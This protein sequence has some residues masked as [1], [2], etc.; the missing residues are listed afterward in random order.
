MKLSYYIMTLFFNIMPMNLS[1]EEE[2]GAQRVSDRLPGS[3]KPISYR[4]DI[5]LK[6]GVPDSEVEEEKSEFWGKV[7]I[8]AK[9]LENTREVVL[10]AEKL[11]IAS[12][13]VRNEQN[14]AISVSYEHK[15]PLLK[16]ET[17]ELKKDEEFSVEIEYSAK[18]SEG[19]SG[20]YK[21][22]DRTQGGTRYI[23]STQFEA[24]H[25]RTAFPCW[26]EPEYK[27]YFTISITAPKKFVVLSNSNEESVEAVEIA[28]ENREKLDS[29]V[30][31]KKVVF[32]PTLLMST[33][34]LAWVIGELESVDDGKIRVFS[35]KGS[36]EHGRYSLG[37]AKHCLEYFNEYFAVPYQMSK[38]DMVAIPDFSAG[39]M[40][41]WG[42][43]T[44]RS[45]SLHYIEGSTTEMQKMWIAETVCHELAH[46]WFG[47]LVTMKWW[48]DLWLNEGFATWAGT[49][50]TASIADKI[51]LKYDVW[52]SF[53]E[54]DITRGMNMDGKLSTHPINMPVSST[55]DISSIFDAISYSKGGSMIHMLANY[56]GYDR[57]KEGLRRYIK[58]HQYKNTVTSD[59]WNSVD[60]DGSKDVTESMKNWIDTAGMPVVHVSLRDGAV[61]LRQ[62]RYLPN[63]TSPETRSLWNVFLTKKQIKEKGAK[64]SSVMFKEERM[65]VPVSEM[66]FIL[67]ENAAGF[68]RVKYSKEVLEKYVKPLLL[69]EHLTS[70]DRYG[71]FRDMAKY[72][73][74][75]Y[76]DAGYL[77]EMLPYISKNEKCAVVSIFAEFLGTVK[78]LF[79]KNERI[80]SAAE[81]ALRNLLEPYEKNV[82]DYKRTSADVE[83]R[84]L[85]IL[86]VSALATIEGTRTQKHAMKIIAGEVMP[87]HINEEYRMRFYI[88]IAKFGDKSSGKDVKER[89]MGG[90]DFLYQIING[91][92]D[93]PE[94]LRATTAIAFSEERT[95]D[96]FR[97]FSEPSKVIRDQDKMR[98]VSGLASNRD[99]K[100]VLAMFFEKFGKIRKMFERTPDHV[101]TFVHG[102]LAP[103]HERDAIEMAG[104][105]FEDSANVE[106]AWKPS[107][108]KG[109]ETAEVN[110]N[111]YERNA[112]VLNAWSL[113]EK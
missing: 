105:F 68:Y 66:P 81:R 15:S 26:D 75:N 3:T 29:G 100:K 106:D 103:L 69:T 82:A 52:E 44:Y 97:L 18:I 87:E 48:N 28:E 96:V 39:A 50:A 78:V 24:P 94:R 38:L 112:E 21:S 62:E 77:L 109:L 6:E 85:E 98:L 9:A 2:S 84:K 32:E 88:A 25:A 58:K 73:L 111:F 67:N 12:A 56:T 17:Q 49:L 55:G 5:V 74:D 72:V 51:D 110:A 1:L 43:V 113:E 37:V 61:E 79:E 20:F 57:F 99:K 4:L 45:S 93:E 23:Y 13:V 10:H 64:S 92:K 22:K 41:N 86:A 54:H 27:A 47:N 104:K 42:L 90:Y 46:Q 33:Y 40:E 35:P 31:Y 59:L 101:A 60:E 89:K 107:I 16:I 34:L 7:R 8:S 65:E 80:K 91:D 14:K 53:L 108:K 70:F 76:E 11:N 95:E 71:I 102:F 36:K 83:Q 30:E 19:L 63:G